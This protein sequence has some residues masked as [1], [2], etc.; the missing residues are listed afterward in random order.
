[1][2]LAKARKGY[3]RPLFD[4]Y[5]H[6]SDPFTPLCL[7]Y[8]PVF[9]GDKLPRLVAGGAALARDLLGDDRFQ[10]AGVPSPGLSFSDEERKKGTG[11]PR[12]DHQGPVAAQDAVASP[13]YRRKA[14]CTTLES[15]LSRR[16][17]ARRVQEEQTFE[18]G[19]MEKGLSGT[20]SNGSRTE[21]EPPS[22]T[23]RQFDAR[24]E[25]TNEAG[26]L[27]CGSRTTR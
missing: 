26:I 24:S 17:H 18:D 19:R 10:L 6:S 8:T 7:F 21:E 22:E 1:M 23:R 20:Y 13:T 11:D 25:E 14:R 2:F 27:S 16:R 5:R 3:V 9:R 4:V 12:D 15:S